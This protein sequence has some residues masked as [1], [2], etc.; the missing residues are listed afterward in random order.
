M[1]PRVGQYVFSAHPQIV[2]HAIENRSESSADFVDLAHVPN[3]TTT[4]LTFS[5]STLFGRHCAILGATG[6]GKSWTIARIL[7][8]VVRHRGKAVLLDPTG[9]FET[10]STRVRHV[11]LGGVSEGAEDER[12]F[13]SFPYRHLSESDLFA[14][15]QPSGGAQ[16]PKL[17]EALLSLKLLHCLPALASEGLLKKA[18]RPKTEYN[19]A[20]M[21]HAA[22][23]RRDGAPYDINSLPNQIDEECVWSTAQNNPNSWGG[24]DNNSRGY[25]ATLVSRIGVQLHS[26]EL[27]AIFQPAE[28]RDLTEVL[29]EFLAHN[30]QNVLRISMEYLP[31]EHNTREL[32][33][34]GFGR[35]LLKKARAGEFKHR[36]LLVVL[37]Q[38]HQFL[39]K[40]V[41]DEFSRFRLESFGL[42]AKEDA[43][44]VS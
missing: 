8:E 28:L 1:H 38:A 39:D 2:K 27:S 37:D 32:I 19:A 36:S 7:G 3:S 26:S 12:E 24:I 22:D 15:F 23:V 14:M 40:H 30:E 4:H 5:S 17:R 13:V 18:S 33:A 21:A 10:L 31:F 20:L 42:I 6:G 25:C 43:S 9:E 29:D 16:S 41:G 11:Y 44:T 34:N 35:Y